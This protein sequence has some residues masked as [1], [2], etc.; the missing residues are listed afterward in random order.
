MVESCQNA[1]SERVRSSTNHKKCRNLAKSFQ[2]H[3]INFKARI[4]K[5]FRPRFKKALV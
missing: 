3:N 5:P 1:S 2:A 4:S